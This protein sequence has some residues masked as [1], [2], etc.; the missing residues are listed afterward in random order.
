[1]SKHVLNTRLTGAL[2]EGD[3]ECAG[4]IVARKSQTRLRP[5][6]DPVRGPPN[7]D[8]DQQSDDTGC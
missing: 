5:L 1:M 7:D 4:T 3:R 2:R 8:R 6:A